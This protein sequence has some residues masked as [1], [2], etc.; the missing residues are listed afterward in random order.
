MNVGRPVCR[1]TWTSEAAWLWHARF[2]YLNF[3]SLKKLASQ[4]M[5][6]GLPV[7]DQVDQV[8]DGCLIGKQRHTSFPGQARQRVESPLDLIHGDMCG[9]IT[10]VTPSGNRYFLLLIDDMSRYMWI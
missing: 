1:A 5:V 4:K 3:R 10:P 8:C 7:L 2:G 9:P 6:Y